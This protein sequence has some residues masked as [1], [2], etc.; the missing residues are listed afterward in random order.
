M[1][2]STGKEGRPN[3]QLDCDKFAAEQLRQKHVSNV[4]R[5]TREERLRIMDPDCLSGFNLTPVAFCS[6][7]EPKK[8]ITYKLPDYSKVSSKIGQ[9][10]TSPYKRHGGNVRVKFGVAKKRNLPPLTPAAPDREA[11]YLRRKE[12]LRE[13]TR[14]L[15]PSGTSPE[16][17]RSPGRGPQPDGG[18]SPTHHSNKQRREQH[19]SD[20]GSTTGPNTTTH[21]ATSSNRSGENDEYSRHNDVRRATDQ[22]PASPESPTTINDHKD[23]DVHASSYANV[24]AHGNS[25]DDDDD[26]DD[27][28]G[29]VELMDGPQ[30]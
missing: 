5:L 28:D 8:V 26:D 9:S 14:K 13:Y 17:R 6:T 12:L 20:S 23:A 7:D 25:N 30:D 29:A 24:A 11:T 3:F 19:G 1:L 27:D 4:Y 21:A 22:T 10:A 18:A 15:D 16:K 2:K